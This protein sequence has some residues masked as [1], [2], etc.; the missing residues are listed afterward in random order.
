[1]LF[2]EET[3]DKLLVFPHFLGDS[4]LPERGLLEKLGILRR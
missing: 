1:M 4:A 3:P 2:S